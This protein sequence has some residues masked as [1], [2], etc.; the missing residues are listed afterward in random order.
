MK[1]AYKHSDGSYEIVTFVT[2]TVTARSFYKD[3]TEVSLQ[4][5]ESGQAAA[6]AIEDAKPKPKTRE[7]KLIDTLIAKGV[8][9]QDDIK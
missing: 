8:I 4:E 5:A 2:D 1:R 6:Q 3:A 9:T 7:Q